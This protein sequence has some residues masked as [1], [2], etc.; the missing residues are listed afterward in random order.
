MI[1]CKSFPIGK[2]DIYGPRWYWL[3]IMMVSK[4][5]VVL[6][7]GSGQIHGALYEDSSGQ[8]NIPAASQLSSTKNERRS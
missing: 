7:P 2:D 4:V 5:V 1:Y 3:N 6:L 8:E